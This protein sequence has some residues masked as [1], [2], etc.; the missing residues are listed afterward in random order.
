MNIEVNFKTFMYIDRS[1]IGGLYF[2]K[3]KNI[4]KL[5]LVKEYNI[6]AKTIYGATN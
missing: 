2:Y 4:T 3:P 1:S 5:L 6:I